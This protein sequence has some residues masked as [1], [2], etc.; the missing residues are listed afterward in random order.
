M[1]A[2]K[3]SWPCLAGKLKEQPDHSQD[4]LTYLPYLVIIELISWSVGKSVSL[5]GLHP[6][7][8]V[9]G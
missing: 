2:R 5:R 7:W 9:E 4:I 1:I 6:T 8:P 3:E